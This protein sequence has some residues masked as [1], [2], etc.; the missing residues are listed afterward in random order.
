MITQRCSVLSAATLALLATQVQAEW[1]YYYF[2]D[3]Q[4]LTLDA[5]RIAIQQSDQVAKRLASEGLAEFDIAA[6]DIEPHALKEWAYA[7][8]PIAKRAD[9]QVRNLVRQIAAGGSVDFV[10]PVFENQQGQSLF[11]TRHIHVGFVADVAAAEAS[12]SHPLAAALREYCEERAEGK[13][14]ALAVITRP[15][16]GVRAEVTGKQVLI[17]APWYLESE[18]VSLDEV[19]NSITEL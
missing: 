15:G 19:T 5:G 4:T 2:K 1:A 6:S 12:V 17:G 14:F 7:Y 8:V 13:A 3:R 18:N 10:S 16:G 11:F 9:M